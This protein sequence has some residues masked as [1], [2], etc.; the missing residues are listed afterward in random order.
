MRRYAITM[1][2]DCSLNDDAT[3][4]VA[5][6]VSDGFVKPLGMWQRPAHLR[7]EAVRDWRVPRETVDDTVREAFKRFHV[8]GFYGDPSHVLD[9]ET[10]QRYWDS[11]F[12]QWH[13]DYGKRLKIWA[14]PSGRD[15]HAIMFDMVDYQVQKRF[16]AA[17]DQTYADIADATMPH[18]GD[19]RLRVHMLNARRQPTRAG[20]SIAKEHRE[21]RRKI[22]LAICAIGARMIRRDY[23]NSGKSRSK[24]VIW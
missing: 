22:D 3:A 23:L 6:R 7:G 2:L 18:D 20:M 19:A 13:R 1:F 5:C 21:S 16:V 9:S 8:I 11:L 24:G 15:R 12:D 10:G 17:V 4:L 14:T